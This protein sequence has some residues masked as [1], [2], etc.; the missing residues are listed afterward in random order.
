MLVKVERNAWRRLALYS[1]LD[2]LSHVLGVSQIEVHARE[3]VPQPHRSWLRGLELALH[4]W[5]PAAVSPS[6]YLTS[7]RR[8][9]TGS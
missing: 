9:I 1:L 6:K 2:R 8:M 3:I 5:I 7:A 4:I